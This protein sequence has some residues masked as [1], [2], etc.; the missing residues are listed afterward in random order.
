MDIS[1]SS[2]VIIEWGVVVAKILALTLFQQNTVHDCTSWR[3]WW[4]RFFLK[5]V[6]PHMKHSIVLVS[7]PLGFGPR[8]ELE[9]AVWDCMCRLRLSERMLLLHIMHVTFLFLPMP[10]LPVLYINDFN[11]R[12]GDFILPWINP[13]FSTSSEVHNN[14]PHQEVKLVDF[15]QWGATKRGT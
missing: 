5:I 7:E 2:T 3:S 12:F 8:Y 15:V 9:S 11:A 6:L 13:W 10:N 1:W 4:L 14:V